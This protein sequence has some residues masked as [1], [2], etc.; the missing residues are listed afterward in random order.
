MRARGASEWPETEETSGGVSG[1]M[2]PAGEAR[3]VR[4]DE[5]KNHTFCAADDVPVA[6]PPSPRCEG[7]SS[8]SSSSSL[9]GMDYVLVHH[10]AAH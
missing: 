3:A 7:T 8:S 1:Y 2:D 5:N 4:S 10:G 6:S 9:G